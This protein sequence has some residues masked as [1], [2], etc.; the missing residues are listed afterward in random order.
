VECWKT[1]SA[2]TA[3]SAIRVPCLGGIGLEQ[4]LEWALAS[5]ERVELVDRRWCGH[6]SARGATQPAAALV[7]A[8]ARLLTEC[9]WPKAA[10]PRIVRKPT[11]LTPIPAAI[12]RPAT[13]VR[14]A[15]RDFLRRFVAQPAP[16]TAGVPVEPHG[17]SARR[18]IRAQPKRTRIL[19]AAAAAASRHGR[20]TP[21][22]LFPQLRASDRCRHHGN[23]AVACP[24]GALTCYDTAT[25]TGIGFRAADCAACGACV[26]ACPENALTLTPRL[27]TRAPFQALQTLTRFP[28]RRCRSCQRTFAATAGDEHCPDCARRH[29]LAL[30]LFGARATRGNTVQHEHR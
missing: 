17:L 11:P 6:C 23:C 5:P 13:G 14:L 22:S 28:Y 30:D 16:V 26:A 10:L 20:D 29:Q 1:P 9:G 8:A 24:T 19:A 27:R 25:E 2:G 7:K 21:R 18:A 3:A 12:P 15:R 4:L